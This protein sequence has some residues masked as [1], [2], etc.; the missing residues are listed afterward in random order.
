MANHAL[1]TLCE[2]I[3]ADRFIIGSPDEVVDK[4]G[5]YGEA[6]G[7]NHLLLRVQ[8]PGLDQKTVLRTLER[9]GRVVEKIE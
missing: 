6:T 8:W 9:L 7:T 4:I 3:A 2:H 5:Q 1:L